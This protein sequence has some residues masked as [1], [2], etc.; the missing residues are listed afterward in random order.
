MILIKDSPNLGYRGEE[1]AV[2]PGYARNYL[3]PQQLV[4]YSTV[5]N[6]AMFMKEKDSAEVRQ[7]SPCSR[8]FHDVAV[9]S[10]LSPAAAAR[11]F[12]ATSRAYA[13]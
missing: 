6:R 13:E 8:S 12:P 9:C 10:S 2:R 4:V 1:V 11:T 5:E 7:Q 3:I